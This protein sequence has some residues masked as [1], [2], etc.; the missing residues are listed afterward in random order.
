MAERG[1]GKLIGRA[2]RRAMWETLEE[3][4]MEP[5]GFGVVTASP[6]QRAICRVADGRPIGDLWDDLG[7]RGAFGGVHP[8]RE[9]DELVIITGIRSG[10]TK[11]GAAAVVHM[12]QHCP[13]EAPSGI[14]LSSGEVPRISIVS[15]K[16]D[17]TDVAFDQHLIGSLQASSTLRELI[18]EEPTKDTLLLWHPDRRPVEVK[19]IAGSRAGSGLVSRWSAGVLFDEAARMMG[20]ED[21]IV[22]LE[23]Q[24]T[25]VRLRLL[26]RAKLWYITSKWA[27]AGLIHKWETEELG[28]PHARVVVSATA[29]VMN[30]TLWTPE[31]VAKAYADD[32]VAARI[33]LGNEYAD[34]EAG[35]FNETVLR[36]LRREEPWTRPY[37]S[38]Q[39]YV[40]AMD[41]AT[42]GN[43]WTLVIVTKDGRNRI[44]VAFARQWT[45]SAAAPLD[46]KAVLTEIRDICRD[47]KL[48]YAHTDQLASDF[49]RSIALDL[50]FGIVI[51]D[52]RGENRTNLYL[53]FAKRCDSGLVELPPDLM[54]SRDLQGIRKRPTGDGG[55]KIVVSKTGDGRHCDYAPPLVAA[56]KQWMDDVRPDVVVDA[57]LKPVMDEEEA[58]EAMSPWSDDG[59]F[60]E[61][62]EYF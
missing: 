47:Y 44:Q 6:L 56:A 52:F 62:L 38:G 55:V 19:V 14:A 13:M 2:N 32:P 33:D 31:I 48:D 22:N 26:R 4:F 25:A 23:D 29:D 20:Q 15:V 46:P 18:V 9:P 24:R 40:A 8:T 35:L 34:P 27:P 1:A 12:S 17:N 39:S 10:K 59:D 41:P 58:V 57:G 28:K 60:E 5:D 61:V 21:G 42:R 45:G 11:L 54:V 7:V 43:S 37:V 51:E 16:I 53:S 36:S 50:G 30:P 49:V 3:L